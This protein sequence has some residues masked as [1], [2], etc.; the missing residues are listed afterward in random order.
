MNQPYLLRIKG[1]GYICWDSFKSCWYLGDRKHSEI[2]GFPF[3]V[4]R[5]HGARAS[6][7]LDSF[8][9]ATIQWVRTSLEEEVCAR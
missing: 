9:T 6:S 2:F 4:F 8:P 7:A 3:G 5:R 1:A